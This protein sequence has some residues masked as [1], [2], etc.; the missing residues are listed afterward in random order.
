MDRLIVSEIDLKM[1]A[2]CIELSKTAG[3]NRE[4]PFA[5]LVCKGEVVVSETINR[6]NRNIDVTRHAELIAVSQAQRALGRN[7]LSDCTLYSTVEPCAMCSFPIRETGICK[8]VFAIRS[9]VMGGFSKFGIL[10]DAE[11]SNI[12]PEIFGDP[13]EIVGGVLVREA[14]KVWRN[15]SPLAWAVIR[16]RGCMGGEPAADA[17]IHWHGTAR[18]RRFNWRQVAHMVMSKVSSADGPA[19]NGALK[20]ETKQRP[21]AKVGHDSDA[22]SRHNHAAAGKCQD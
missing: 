10:Q 2:R 16:Y 7:D 8:V 9:P 14:E 18:P 12:V 17:S 20:L 1:M 11:L 15:C 13:P 19:A 21:V 22:D 3:G 4:F 6:V 5:S